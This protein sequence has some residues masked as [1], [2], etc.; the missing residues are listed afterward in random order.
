MTRHGARRSRDLAGRGVGTCEAC[1]KLAHPDR[2]AAKRARTRMGDHKL[3]A[4]PC[5]DGTGYWHLG[6]LPKAVVWGDV[7]RS[8]LVRKSDHA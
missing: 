7:D 3:S 8:E 5:P 1:G 6:H 2:K 4:Y